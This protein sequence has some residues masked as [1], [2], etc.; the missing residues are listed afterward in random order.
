MRHLIKLLSVLFAL[1][2]AQSAWAAYVV[3][4]TSYKTISN[5]EEKITKSQMVAWTSGDVIT[6]DVTD[7]SL[8]DMSSL[9]KNKTAFNQDLSA[10]DKSSITTETGYCSS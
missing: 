10:W 3:N 6:C 7:N 8:N 4:G 1:S 9:F 2:F 5:S